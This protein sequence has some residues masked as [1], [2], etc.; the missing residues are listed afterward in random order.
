MSNRSSQWWARV[1]QTCACE[2]LGC[3]SAGQNK[4]L[5][6]V[7]R[8]GKSCCRARSRFPAKHWQAKRWPCGH[9]SAHVPWSVCCKLPWAHRT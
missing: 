1:I 4:R 2:S 9:K 7:A 5:K 8:H 6:L 3:T